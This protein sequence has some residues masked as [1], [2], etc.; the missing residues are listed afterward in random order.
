MDAIYK[1][2]ESEYER[3]PNYGI[4]CINCDSVD[5]KRIDI[6]RWFSTVPYQSH[7]DLACEGRVAQTGEW[8]FKRKEFVGWQDSKTSAILWLH[9]IR[10]FGYLS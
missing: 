10:K 2:I 3:N 7:H 8:L 6:L 4:S 1:G 5:S 9:G